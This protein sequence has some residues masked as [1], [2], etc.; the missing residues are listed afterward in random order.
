MRLVIHRRILQ[1]NIVEKRKKEMMGNSTHLLLTKIKCVDGSVKQTNKGVILNMKVRPLGIS[2][3][4]WYN[5]YIT[6]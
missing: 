2:N 4:K 1:M 6:Y 3:V 5:F